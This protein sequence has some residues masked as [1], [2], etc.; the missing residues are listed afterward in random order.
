MDNK[1]IDNIVWWIPIKSLRNFAREYLLE[2]NDLKKHN[3]IDESSISS[4]IIIEAIRRSIELTTENLD[5]DYIKNIFKKNV[6]WV[7]IGISSFCN[8]KCW[9]CPNSFIDRFSQNLILEEKLFIKVL[10]ELQEID[11]SNRIYLHRYNEP[12]YDKD[13]LITRI[14]QVRKYLPNCNITIFSNGDYLTSDY[15]E[16]LNKYRVNNII[17]TYYYNYNDKNIPFDIDNIIHPGMIKLLNKLKLEYQ[18]VIKNDL[19]YQIDCNYKNI[20]INYRA[21]DFRKH[22]TDRGQLLKDSVNIVNNNGLCFMPN[23]HLAVDY[24]GNYTLCCNIRSDV[25]KHENYILG[26]IKDSTIFDIF[27]GTKMINFRK[28]LMVE[29]KRIE[30][31]STCSDPRTWENLF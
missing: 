19:Y 11:Y 17:I 12:L 24:D 20:Y 1:T 4:N 14:K 27:M 28:K 23:F 15:L 8:R 16:L 29:A 30:I 13:L 10:S 5:Y 9:F 22:A 7:E 2:L 21:V 3:K 18:V 26:N 25:K 31:C 6:T